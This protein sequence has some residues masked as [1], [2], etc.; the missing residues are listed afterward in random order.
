MVVVA[1]GIDVCPG[2]GCLARCGWD[3]RA[4]V[5]VAAVAATVVGAAAVVAVVAVVDATLCLAAGPGT[6]FT[7]GRVRC[8]LASI[9]TSR[10]TAV[11]KKRIAPARP[12]LEP[13]G[14]TGGTTCVSSTKRSLPPRAGCN[15]HQK[16]HALPL[17][18]Q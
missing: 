8:P 15:P 3:R 4:V 16:P 6:V 14:G 18:R 7:R 11:A 10:A 12:T 9:A 1:A 2:A 5:V 13:R 17:G